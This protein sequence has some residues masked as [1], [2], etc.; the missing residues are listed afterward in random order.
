MIFAVSPCPLNIS[1]C[2][3]IGIAMWFGTPSE[4]IVVF[5]A[6]KSLKGFLGL[7]HVCPVQPLILRESR[8]AESE[9]RRAHVS[10]EWNWGGF[11][12]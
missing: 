10:A 1:E 3:Q 2:C 9:K 4:A 6:K 7:R 5:E 11:F 12:W 8:L